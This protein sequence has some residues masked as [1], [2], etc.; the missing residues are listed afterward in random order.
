MSLYDYQISKE[1]EGRDHPFYALIM[2]CMRKADDIN[3]GKLKEMWPETYE[4]LKARF[5][6]P[7]GRLHDD[8]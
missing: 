6:S 5:N 2:A 4:E 7:G 3:I 1:I 8:A